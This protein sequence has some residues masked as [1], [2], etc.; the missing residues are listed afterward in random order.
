MDRVAESLSD[1]TSSWRRVNK[2]S[3]LPASIQIPE[4]VFKLTLHT[5]EKQQTASIQ[6]HVSIVCKA[7]SWRWRIGSTVI[8]AYLYKGGSQDSGLQHWSSSAM[9]IK[10]PS[11]WERL[12]GDRVTP[13]YITSI[14]SFSFSR[15]HKMY[16]VHWK[17]LQMWTCVIASGPYLKY[18]QVS[19]NPGKYTVLMNSGSHCCSFQL[20]FISNTFTRYSQ[21]T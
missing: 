19:L 15:M 7:R 10:L 17:N 20:D 3:G 21:N 18:L 6:K 4:G 1:L 14:F 5:S 11:L 9:G 13:I 8:K 12:F 2:K 16:N